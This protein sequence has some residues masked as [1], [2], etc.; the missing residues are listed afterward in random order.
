MLPSIDNLRCFVA[1][2]Q[3]LNFRAAARTVALTPAAVGQRIRQL[4]DQVGVA[5]FKRTTRSV[6]LT[7]E[8]L[9]LLPVAH[10][11]LQTAED[12]VRAARGQLGPGPTELVLGTRHELG[13]SWVVPQMAA[14]G[15]AH[16]GVTFHLYFGS[17]DDLLLRIRLREIDCAVTSSRFVDPKLDA[18]QLHREDYVFVGARSMLR[19]SP[20]T[21]DEHAQNHTLIDAGRDLVLFRYWRDAAGAGDRLRFARI[22]RM[23]T[24]SAIDHCV[25]SG[26]GVAVLPRYL[27]EGHLA[28]GTLIEVFPKVKPLPDFFRLVFRTDDPRR[29]LFES[30]ART[31]ITRPLR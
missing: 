12:C 13:L 7:R 2:A 25:R 24:I 6:S 20:L 3:F 18:L 14:L 15:R 29:P 23:G 28:K 4:E 8:G 19:R 30:I 16:D 5:L 26:E 10:R 31:M 22:L 21:R 9:A 27:V 1:A 17:G 11:T